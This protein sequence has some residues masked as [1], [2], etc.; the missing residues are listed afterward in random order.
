MENMFKDFNFDM[1]DYIFKNYKF[2]EFPDFNRGFG[3]DSI[4]KEFNFQDSNSYFPSLGKNKM[5]IKSFKDDDIKKSADSAEKAKPGMD[6][7]IFGK[8]ENGK[9]MTFNKKII[10][11]NN[12]INSKNNNKDAFQT[13]IFPN[14][15]DSYFN[16]SFQLDSKNKT[17]II[18]SDINGKQLQKEIIDKTNGIYT[19]QFDMKDYSKGTYIINIKQGKKSVSKQIII[20]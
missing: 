4:I 2:P 3:I 8:D 19:R 14:P 9:T 1:N 11:Q 6:L 20:E 12:T 13:D 7:Q 16:V 15:A 10:I 17:T 18:I 5:I